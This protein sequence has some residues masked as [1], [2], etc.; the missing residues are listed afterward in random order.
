MRIFSDANGL[1]RVTG[2]TKISTSCY[3][4]PTSCLPSQPTAMFT[5]DTP[6]LF[7]TLSLLT[8]T[9]SVIIKTTGRQTFVKDVKDNILSWSPFRS[10][11]GTITL[12]LY[13][14]DLR[15]LNIAGIYTGLK[16]LPYLYFPS[17]P[18]FIKHDI[19]LRFTR[20]AFLIGV[21]LPLYMTLLVSTSHLWLRALATSL[22]AECVLVEVLEHYWNPSM[23]VFTVRRDWPRRALLIVQRAATVNYPIHAHSQNED[24]VDG[25]GEGKED[26]QIE[27]PPASGDNLC[28]RIQQ[29]WSTGADSNIT[30]AI[31]SLP[32]RHAQ[33]L[34]RIFS[35]H[36]RT[37]TWTCGHW[38]CAVFMYSHLAQRIILLSWYLEQAS[39]AWLLHVALH[40]VTLHVADVVL[41]NNIVDGVLTMFYQIS[42]MI[43]LVISAYISTV[44]LFL[45]LCKHERIGRAFQH[46][47]ETAPVT[48][49]ALDL[50]G[51]AIMPGVMSFVSTRVLYPRDPSLTSNMV[52]CAID[53]VVILMLCIIG[54]RLLRTGGTVN[55]LEPTT[56][57]ESEAQS[58]P[59]LSME[60]KM[61]HKSNDRGPSNSGATA[62]RQTSADDNVRASNSGSR[63]PYRLIGS[64]FQIF[65]LAIW[66][67]TGILWGFCSY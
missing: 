47:A 25:S 31:H 52:S 6:W 8:A 10:G 55:M 63:Y 66:A 3:F 7:P 39:T 50:F 13:L 36:V 26:R 21:T 32:P 18:P 58:D 27:S 1:S 46:L 28:D 57:A 37:S 60:P 20:R 9:I 65:R 44:W 42:L 38:R 23:D 5:L 4:L 53:F 40:P 35:L 11:R 56:P 17:E 16:V 45:R 48:Y 34:D 12:I 61:A 15:L 24:E 51:K 59:S 2:L 49:K 64:G 67:S 43:I 62:P 19:W 14:V 41:K 54:Y 33:K 29:L 30:F 22:V